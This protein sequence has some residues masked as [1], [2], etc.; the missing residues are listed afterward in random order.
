MATSALTPLGRRVPCGAGFKMGVVVP[1]CMNISSSL[2]IQKVEFSS[3]VCYHP[4]DMKF[5]DGLHCVLNCVP[6]S[7]LTCLL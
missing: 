7:G 6:Y 1:E 2:G 3:E 4:D 5:E